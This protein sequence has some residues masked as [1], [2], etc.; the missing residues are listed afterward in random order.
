MPQHR[1][2]PFALLL[3]LFLL[4]LSPLA[5]SPLALGPDAGEQHDAQPAAE[6]DAQPDADGDPAGWTLSAGG[7]LPRVGMGSL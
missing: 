3:A 2:S 6:P 1:H 4:A 5:L 7:Y